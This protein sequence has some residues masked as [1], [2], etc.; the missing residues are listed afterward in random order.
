MSRINS[1]RDSH[2]QSYGV[3]A[4]KVFA[5][6][7][8]LTQSLFAWSQLSEEAAIRHYDNMPPPGTPNAQTAS[9]FK[10]LASTKGRNDEYSVPVIIW[11][12]DC[13]K[14]RCQVMSRVTHETEFYEAPG[15]LLD[16]DKLE[17]NTIYEVVSVG[18]DNKSSGLVTIVFM[19]PTDY[20][21]YTGPGQ[22]K[23]LN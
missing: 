23:E 18:F 7:T 9:Y 21:S 3:F 4:V 10:L 17:A 13:V 20:E 2:R 12:P 11:D 15:R 5:V 22:E 6:L 19:M 14:P 8:F 1:R 16:P